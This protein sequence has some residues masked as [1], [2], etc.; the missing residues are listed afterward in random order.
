MVIFC[1]R[2]ENRWCQ[3]WINEDNQCETKIKRWIK[4]KRNLKSGTEIKLK[5][6][7]KSIS[8]GKREKN[9]IIPIKT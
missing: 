4:L 1:E 3:N 2:I 9:E 8:K 7:G 5:I 6:K